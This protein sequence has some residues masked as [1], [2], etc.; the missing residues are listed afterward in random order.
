MPIPG[1]GK[2]G[3]G[4]GDAPRARREGHQQRIRAGLQP[5][6]LPPGAGAGT[7][8]GR[9]G[10]L[11]GEA[12]PRQR[13]FPR[14]LPEGLPSLPLLAGTEGPRIAAHTVHTAAEVVLSDLACAMPRDSRLP[15]LRRAELLSKLLFLEGY[16]LLFRERGKEIRTFLQHLMFP[17]YPN[18]KKGQASLPR[19][20]KNL[21][22]VRLILDFLIR[23]P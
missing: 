1:W 10:R 5:S 13:L 21:V 16:P 23:R 20:N 18:G 15:F 12:R 7:S 6:P 11:L 8:E 4:T 3:R 17:K 9:R 22:S 19:L 2:R 14:M